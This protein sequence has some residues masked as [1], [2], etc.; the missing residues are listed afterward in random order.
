MSIYLRSRLYIP[1]PAARIDGHRNTV[2]LRNLRAPIADAFDGGHLAFHGR[3]FIELANG[4][5]QPVGFMRVRLFDDRS[6]R[7]VRQT[8]SDALGNYAFTNLASAHYRIDASDPAHQYEGVSA[9][10]VVPV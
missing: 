4:T 1:N 10:W 9:D 7:L 3:T 2:A 8:F 6:G 5:Q